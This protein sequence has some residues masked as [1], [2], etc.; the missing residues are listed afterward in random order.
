VSERGASKG[1]EAEGSGQFGD[2][3]VKPSRQHAGKFA[4]VSPR[5]VEMSLYDTEQEA[6][7]ALL[8]NYLDLL[9]E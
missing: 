5:N 8:D 1:S 3:R 9:G 7:Q 2:Y 6:E 4:I